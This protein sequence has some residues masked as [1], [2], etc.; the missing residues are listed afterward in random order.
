MKNLL[1]IALLLC[2]PFLIKAQSTDNTLEDL[3]DKIR[4]TGAFGG[5]NIH[6]NNT[7]QGRFGF[8]IANN[9]DISFQTGSFDYGD[10]LSPLEDLDFKGIELAY[11]PLEDRVFHPIISAS[12][13]RAKIDFDDFKVP[14]VE[15]DFE[16]KINCLQT[17]VG[18]EINVFRF[19][20]LGFH[21]GLNMYG[22]ISKDLLIEKDNLPQYFGQISMKFGGFWD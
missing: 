11:R 12:Y 15:E 9:F 3:S 7:L 6:E 19:F 21:G 4:L 10:D 13:N 2:V 16:Y 22:D 20:K 17:K 14:S 1:N 8:E 5:L 18:M